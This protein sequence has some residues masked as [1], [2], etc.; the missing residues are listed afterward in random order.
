VSGGEETR[1]K[2]VGELRHAI[3]DHTFSV[4]F[5]EPCG[6]PYVLNETLR[7]ERNVTLINGLAERGFEG[8]A[9]RFDY[10]CNTPDGC[11]AAAKAKGFGFSD[12]V[13]GYDFTGAA[14]FGCYA[15]LNDNQYAGINF[16][17]LGG[18]SKQVDEDVQTPTA[19]YRVCS[20]GPD[21][22][23]QKN[24]TFADNWQYIVLDAGAEQQSPRSV[25][26]VASSVSV[27]LVGLEITGGAGPP[28]A[29][30]YSTWDTFYSSLDPP[31]GIDNAG[32]LTIQLSRIRGNLGTGIRN[33]GSLWVF[34]SEISENIGA[35][36]GGG[37]SNYGRLAVSTSAIH[38]NAA[39]YAGG[40]ILHAADERSRLLI[41]G[42][43]VSE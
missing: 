4:I 35:W 9:T 29:S 2:T 19:N 3:N 13:D 34:D 33:V 16:F 10:D 26:E 40:G 43:T 27:K 6:S 15:H 7:I 37:I 23:V 39:C 17:G 12:L 5:L 8:A 32:A 21:F 36:T 24:V 38:A 11:R 25:I 31:G 14:E 30:H 22:T 42:S 28:C 1:V 20:E 18:T 41:S